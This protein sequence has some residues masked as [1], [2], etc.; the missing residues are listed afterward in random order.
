MRFVERKWSPP[1]CLAHGS[2]RSHPVE[3][4]LLRHPPR[5]SIPAA[6][7]DPM[8][9]NH[10]NS[11][12][13]PTSVSVKI[14]PSTASTANRAFTRTGLIPRALFF[15]NRRA[16]TE[17]EK[18]SPGDRVRKACG[19]RISGSHVWGLIFGYL[20]GRSSLELEEDDLVMVFVYHRIV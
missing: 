17:T 15:G 10:S 2:H 7:G 20:W 8:N 18:R 13:R 9:R 16:P 4:Y 11:P 3:F 14:A 5:N 12:S 1:P 6:I 19:Q